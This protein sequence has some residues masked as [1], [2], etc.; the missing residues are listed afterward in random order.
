MT[1]PPN[2]PNFTELEDQLSNSGDMDITDSMDLSSL[3]NTLPSIPSSNTNLS[4]HANLYNYMTHL[5]NHCNLRYLPY[6]YNS[7]HQLCFFCIRFRSPYITRYALLYETE[8]FFIQSG[9]DDA[10]MY[11]SSYFELLHKW[12]DQKHIPFTKRD[13]EYQKYLLDMLEHTH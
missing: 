11:Y 7:D 4:S 5:C 13:H 10:R 8:W 12:A 3:R 2:S 6:W 9:E 1:C